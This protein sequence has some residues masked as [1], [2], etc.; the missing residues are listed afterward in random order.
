MYIRLIDPLCCFDFEKTLMYSLGYDT[1][2]H[3]YILSNPVDSQTSDVPPVTMYILN[4]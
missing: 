3:L 2:C 4:I 1:I